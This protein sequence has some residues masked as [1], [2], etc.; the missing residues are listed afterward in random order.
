[1]IAGH[2]LLR[3]ILLHL[4]L[5]ITFP[6]RSLGMWG[7]IMTRQTQTYFPDR[8]Q[9]FTRPSHLPQNTSGQR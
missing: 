5:R 1:M 9:D 3:F 6:H 8:F 2:S 7:E 4:C